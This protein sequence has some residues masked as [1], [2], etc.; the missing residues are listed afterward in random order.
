MLHDQSPK[1][2]HADQSHLSIV[3][4]FRWNQVHSGILKADGVLRMVEGEVK[5]VCEYSS[6][7]VCAGPPEVMAMVSIQASCFP[8]VHSQVG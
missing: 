3:N 8:Q 4:T 1:A 7:L 6:Q 5:D 2:L